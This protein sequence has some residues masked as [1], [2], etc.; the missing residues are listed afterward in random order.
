M[1]DAGQMPKPVK[2]RSRV[3][4]S[5]QVIEH[6][7]PLAVRWQGAER[8]RIRHLGRLNGNL[9]R[10]G[11]QCRKRELTQPVVAWTSVG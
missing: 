8:E 5:R 2:L 4:W 1:S 9:N 7:S 11:F 3:L 10:S 6:G